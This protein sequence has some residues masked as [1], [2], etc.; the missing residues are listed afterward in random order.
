MRK[1][2]ILSCLALLLS[3]CG[4]PSAGSSPTPEASAS[5]TAGNVEPVFE[6]EVVK[7]GEGE[8][9]ADNGAAEVNV[10]VW[11]DKYEGTPFGQGQFDAT[12]VMEAPELPGLG[13]LAKGIK[14]GGVR[15]A[16]VNAIALFGKVPPG[17][18]FQA[19][20]LFYVEM[21]AKK[22]FPHEELE[23]K[24][25]K[26]GKGRA[27]KTGDLVEVHMTGWL[28]KFD[29]KDVFNSTRDKEPAV[30]PIGS[31]KNP[32]WDKGLAGMKQGEV[33]RIVI[34]H[35]LAFGSNKP[36]NVTGYPK[37]YL[38][39]ELLG[40]IE[41]GELKVE[42]TKEGKGEGAKSGDTVYVHYTG[43]TGG[44]ESDS[45]FDSSLDRGQPFPV[46]LGQGRVIPGWE[47][48]LLGMKV[49][50]T[51][52]L[53]IPFNLGYGSRGSPPKIPPYATLYFEVQRLE[54]PKPAET[55]KAEEKK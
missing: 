12:L 37:L 18:P 25:V 3:A 1:L 48:G 23:I 46:T 17:A 8:A 19:D 7:E 16:K 28:D 31:D 4:G 38:E 34:P 5:P 47:Q 13:R 11:R 20:Q 29:N 9:V 41:E 6:D 22:V 2:L 10:K 45:K 39:V 36:K 30:L 42:T 24:T 14:E 27:A 50:E 49:G 21:T 54:T 51:R 32:G 52:R 40:F 33:R 53:T 44:F 15:R 43:W 26:E 55:P 35:Y